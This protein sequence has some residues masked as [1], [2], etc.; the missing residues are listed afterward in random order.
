MLGFVDYNIDAVVKFGGSLLDDKVNC[1]KAICSLATAQQKGYRILVIPGGGPTD[2]TIE[3]LDKI[4]HFE[5]NT[6]HKACAR[7]QDQTGIMICD[8]F[9]SNSLVPCENLEDVD[10]A[11]NEKKVAVLLPS[12]I[13][14]DMNPFE[15]IWD[16]TS[17]A[18]AAWFAWVTNAKKFIV[19]KSVDGVFAN[20]NLDN[21]T[22]L[23]REILAKDLIKMGSN[24]VDACVAPFLLQKKMNGYIINGAGNEALASIL[25]EGDFYGTIVI[26]KE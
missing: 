26:G 4:Y 22:N 20:N 12:K 21:P 1:K 24:A 25:D 8:K 10:K 15:K 14:F 23:I 17:D 5:S 11:L 6:H 13:I 3:R 19:F 9:F 7:A 18:M 16:I 2:N